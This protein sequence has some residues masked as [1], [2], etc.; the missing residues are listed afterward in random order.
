MNKN[1]NVHAKDLGEVLLDVAELLMTYGASSNRVRL[2]VS[3]ISQSFGFLSDLLIVNTAITLFLHKD[4]EEAYNSLRRTSQ[5]MVNF[6]KVSGIS[7]MSWKI[8]E[9]SMTLE[10]IKAELNLIKELTHFNR[11]VVLILVSVA[12]A[13]FCRIFDGSPTEMAVTF[14]ATFL[15]LFVRQELVKQKLMLYVTIYIAAFVSSFTAGLAGVLFP[16]ETMEHAF[17][18]SVLFLIPGVP[19]I[20]SSSDLLDGNILTGL[21]RGINALII[22]FAIS[23]GIL[24]TKLIFH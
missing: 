17:A 10:Q 12:G 22:G 7:R 3:R 11:F 8:V 16:G 2:T 6:R 5:P 13:S 9:S 21:S 14:V 4:N 18:A 24:T 1:Q 15:G 23:V 19:L 20:N